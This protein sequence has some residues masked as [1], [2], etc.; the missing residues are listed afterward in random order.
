MVRLPVGLQ[1]ERFANKRRTRSKNGLTGLSTA[2]ANHVA[3]LHLR[4][5]RLTGRRGRDIFS[6]M[7]NYPRKPLTEPLAAYVL[8]AELHARQHVCAVSRGL[9]EFIAPNL[10]RS[11]QTFYLDSL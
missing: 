3:S 5:R 8:Q 2:D 4:H 10:N 11:K 6:K 7:L 1:C 9:R